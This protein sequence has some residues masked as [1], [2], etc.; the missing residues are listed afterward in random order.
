[1]AK[2]IKCPRCDLNYML[3]TEK[4][5]DACKAELGLGP[6]LVFAVDDEDEEDKTVLCPD[7]GQN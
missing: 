3:D 1:M 4:Y 5:C 7:C 6:K 2:Y